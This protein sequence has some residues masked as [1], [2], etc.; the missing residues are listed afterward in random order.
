MAEILFITKAEMTNTTILCGNVDFDKYSFCVLDT[1]LRV[2]EPLLGTELYEKIK[3]DLEAETLSG[4]YL[5]MF[6]D[7]VKPI[8][9][10]ASVANYLEI[11]SYLV[12]NGGVYKHVADNKQVVEKNEVMSLVQKYNGM[13]DMFIIRFQKWICKNHLVEYKT[14]QD[15]VNADKDIKTIFGWK[16]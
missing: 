15:K 11:A 2:L 4:L 3:T 5:E 12:D 16:L 6:N 9:K 13:T 14:Y 8:T 10:F 7:Y 1:Q